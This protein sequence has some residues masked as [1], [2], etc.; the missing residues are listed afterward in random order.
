MWKIGVSADEV[1]W[2]EHAD[3]MRKKAFQR[4]Q[5]ETIR[6]SNDHSI[7][8]WDSFGMTQRSDSVLADDPSDLQGCGNA[9]TSRM[10]TGR[11]QPTKYIGADLHG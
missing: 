3:V 7:F 1:V 11:F 6:V 5:L 2:G 9:G 4:L 8:A 10:V